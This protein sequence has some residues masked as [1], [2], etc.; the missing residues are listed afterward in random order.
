MSLKVS[1]FVCLN[2]M[3]S[4]VLA[5]T[6]VCVAFFFMFGTDDASVPEGG[7]VDTR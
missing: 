6:R 4:K 1:I 7:E 3:D 2:S 5:T